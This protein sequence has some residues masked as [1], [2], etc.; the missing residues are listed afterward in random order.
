[1]L[2]RYVMYVGTEQK[3]EDEEIKLQQNLLS[4]RSIKD[5]FFNLNID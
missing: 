2:V 1:M 4:Y 3:E 5:V